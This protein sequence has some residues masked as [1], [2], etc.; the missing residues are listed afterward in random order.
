M[1][2]L[3]NARE[4]FDG[5]RDPGAQAAHGGALRFSAK[6]DR[7]VTE[8]RQEFL[9]EMTKATIAG[10]NGDVGFV[11]APP[12]TIATG[13]IPGR[14]PVAPIAKR[15]DRAGAVRKAVD[16]YEMAKSAGAV[17]WQAMEKEWTLTT[18]VTTGLVPYDLPLGIAA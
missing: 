11:Q 4:L 5:S 10:L 7:E 13:Y 3:P 8:D 17:D 2:S 1:P 18:P 9:S 14:G 12:D 16:S 15:S 6:S